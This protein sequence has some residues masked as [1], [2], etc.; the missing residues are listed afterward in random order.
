MRGLEPEQ[1]LLQDG[2]GLVDGEPAFLKAL[3]EGLS[4]VESH[5]HKKL[6]L[7]FSD[8]VENADVRMVERTR[9]PRFAQESSFR[10]FAGGKVSREELDGYRPTE[11][12][13]C[14]SI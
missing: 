4:F 13:V 7:L 2:D 9:G 12:E 6:A 3:T 8:V 11:L 14:R 1:N 5:H 10:L